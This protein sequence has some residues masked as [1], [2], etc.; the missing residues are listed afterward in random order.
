MQP[1]IAAD[2]PPRVRPSNYPP[3]FA[4]RMEGRIKRPLGDPS[5]L[6][7]FGVNLTTLAAG[8]VSALHH[9][10]SVQD[11]FIY[12]LDGELWLRLGEEEFRMLPG[13]CMGFPAQGPA[14][15]LENRGN[16]PATYL[17]I[18]DRSAG[19]V[20]SYPADDLVAQRVGDGWQ[21]TRK[22]GSR[23]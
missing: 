4:R 20:V 15:H 11:E 22:D 19:D 12:L 21:F 14:H 2:A 3:E 17:E 9:S 23:Y 1:L 8:S 5:G 13:M 6:R 10:H 7:N 16:H 18:G